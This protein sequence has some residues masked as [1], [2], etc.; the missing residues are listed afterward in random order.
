MYSDESSDDGQVR[1]YRSIF[2]NPELP[3]PAYFAEFLRDTC[4]ISNPKKHI[5]TSEVGEGVF[6]ACVRCPPIA[7][8][9]DKGLI[10]LHENICKACEGTNK[11][12]T[13]D[14]ASKLV[15]EKLFDLGALNEYTAGPS[16]AVQRPY[17]VA[18]GWDRHIDL[19]MSPGTESKLPDVSLPEG[20]QLHYI[21][22]TEDLEEKTV[23]Q[24]LMLDDPPPS[25]EP[26]AHIIGFD[27]EWRP[28]LGGKPQS[29][30]FKPSPSSPVAVV[31]LSSYH[32]T[33]VVNL[34]ALGSNMAPECTVWSKCQAAI[35]VVADVFANGSLQKVGLQ[36]GE[37]IT[38]IKALACNA[39][40]HNVADC[41]DVAKAIGFQRLG[42][43]ALM[44]A[45]FGRNMIKVEQ[46]TD[47]QQEELCESMIHYAALDAW[48][49]RELYIK[50]LALQ[51]RFVY[52]W[53]N[54]RSRNLNT[55]QSSY[56]RIRRIVIWWPPGASG[57]LGTYRNM[58]KKGVYRQLQFLTTNWKRLQNFSSMHIEIH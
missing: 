43:R 3:W 31:Q 29:H 45:V 5:Y 51:V 15:L 4:G 28:Q 18:E 12:F 57:H 34:L 21:A 6:V 25:D 42:L 17:L 40:V 32:S 30:K 26:H 52:G 35:A 11:K 46:T 14:Q 53:Q 49:T 22:S 37:D 20:H 10:T 47:W 7:T 36:G 56:N 38:R 27:I 50:L 44:A 1:A 2:R 24:L 8:R 9:D 58:T 19:A 54:I 16:D 41:Q 55:R 48:C 33:V 23:A 13:K 39:A